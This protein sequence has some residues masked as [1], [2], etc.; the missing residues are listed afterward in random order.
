MACNPMIP[1]LL[2]HGLQPNDTVVR[3][4]ASGDWLRGWGSGF[5]GKTFGFGVLGFRV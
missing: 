3:A 5:R 2:V 4:P 1:P